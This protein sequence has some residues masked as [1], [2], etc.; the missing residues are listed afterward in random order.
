MNFSP[1][2]KLKKIL[3]FKNSYADCIKLRNKNHF[4]E[5]TLWAA[6]NQGNELVNELATLLRRIE[7]LS[8]LNNDH[9]RV[10]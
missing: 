10:N 9:E 8:N 2:G 5:D 1:N 7:N 6:L 3:D 4:H